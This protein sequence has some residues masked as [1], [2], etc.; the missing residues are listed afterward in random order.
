M[1]FGIK[2]KLSQLVLLMGLFPVM[3]LA[4]VYTFKQCVETTLGQ[5]PSLEVSKYKLQQA[6]SALSEASL[7]RLPQ[8]TLSATATRS[9]NALNVFGMK[10][11]QRD[12]SFRDFGFAEFNATNPNIIAVKPKDLN[13]PDAHND[14]STRLEVLFPV[15]NGGKVSAYQGKASAMIKAAQHGDNA[16]K[17]FLIFNVYQA[18]EAV[19]TAKAFV[20]VATQAV[21]ASRS[22]VRTTK[23]LLKQGIVVKSELLSAKVSLSQAM[24]SL[25]LAEAKVLIA[26]DNLRSLMFINPDSPLKVGSRKDISLPNKNLAEFIGMAITKN[27]EI[28]ATRED[29][30]SSKVAV[31]SVDADNYP[32]FNVMARGQTNDASLGFNSNSY[33]VA[34]VLSWKL[35]DFGVTASRVDRANALA[36]EKRSKLVVKENKIKLEILK[37][38]RML[39]VA[40]KRFISNKLSVEQSKEAQRLILKRHRGGVATIAEVLAGQTQ[41]D[42]TR[43]DLV[44]SKYEINLQKAKIKLAIGAMNLEQF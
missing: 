34:G 7:S 8:V 3:A 16:L 2:N 12:A 23:N 19:H 41:L 32:S 11:S 25:Q 20:Q 15:W 5:N 31:A 27:P 6:K 44:S 39:N 40:K 29:A 18:Y 30:R 26:K 10:L 14:F 4:Q 43:A 13:N 35:T 33:T 28:K 42:K 1:Q 9:N 38:W 21:K 17:Q 22:Y 36:N 24:T 37:A